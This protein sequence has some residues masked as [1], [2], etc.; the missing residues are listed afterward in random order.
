MKRNM[1]RIYK[2]L[3]SG[4]LSIGMLCAGWSIPMAYAA[5]NISVYIDGNYLRTDVP[6]YI[7]NGYTMLPMRAVY[8]SLGANVRYNSQSKEIIISADSDVLKLYIGRKTAYLNGSPISLSV[9]P[10]IKDGRTMVGLRD[11]ANLI[12]ADID[13]DSELRK[14]SVRTDD[15]GDKRNNKTSSFDEIKEGSWTDERNQRVGLSISKTSGDKAEILVQWSSS[16]TKGSEWRIQCKWNSEK[17]VLEYKNCEAWQY[18]YDNTNNCH[19]ELVYDNGIG[20]FYFD[21]G[22]LHWVDKNDN[23]GKDCYFTFLG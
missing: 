23:A 6:P 16:V 2:G 18:Y 12:G 8:E 4:A 11:G 3:V 20:Y 5:G 9:S 17:G 22:Y 10:E 13:W 19:K 14:V 21:S 7:K 15:E 1:K